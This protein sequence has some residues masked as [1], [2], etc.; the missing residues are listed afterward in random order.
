MM[1]PPT[2]KERLEGETYDIGVTLDLGY[3]LS[4]VKAALIS[5]VQSQAT[6]LNLTVATIDITF[7]S[8]ETG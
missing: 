4:D 5:A 6:T 8:L 7:P 1:S 2:L 3:S